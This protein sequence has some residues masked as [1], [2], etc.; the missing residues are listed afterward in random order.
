MPVGMLEAFALCD[1]VG[2][3]VLSFDEVLFMA[4]AKKRKGCKTLKSRLTVE[5]RKRVLMI[6]EKCKQW[7]SAR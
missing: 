4:D 2:A 1:E 7:R 6:G 5:E 3:K